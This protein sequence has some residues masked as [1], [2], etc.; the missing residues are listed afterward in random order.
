MGTF[1]WRGTE[2]RWEISIY[3][4]NEDP[5]RAERFIENKNP[6]ISPAKAECLRF[7]CR[8]SVAK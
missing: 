1:W 7:F 2:R 3:A 4:P 5:N 6:R 8:T